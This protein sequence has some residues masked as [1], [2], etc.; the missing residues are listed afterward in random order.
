MKNE[1]RIKQE[2]IE[3]AYGESYERCNPDENGYVNIG[4]CCNGDDDV[5]DILN[6]YD[7]KLTLSDLDIKN[8][9]PYGEDGIIIFRPKSLI[10]IEDNNSWISVKDRLPENLD[11]KVHL[12]HNDGILTIGH[13]TM[14]CDEIDEDE[15]HINLFKKYYT[16]WQPIVKPI[17][18]IY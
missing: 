8:S 16:H 15:Y 5:Q 10:G 18:P 4:F 7:I 13:V 12:V 14:F 11:E 2:A 9:N 17:P 3:K 1:K 6:D